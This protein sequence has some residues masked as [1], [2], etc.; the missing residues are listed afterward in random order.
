LLAAAFRSYKRFVSPFLPPACRFQPTCS[1]YAAQAVE[2]HGAAKG[3][4]LA[5]GRIL[6][7]H[8]WSAGGFDPVP[9]AAPPTRG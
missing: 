3:S 6:R 5:A 1:E 7:C 4:L 2:I 9:A 8:P